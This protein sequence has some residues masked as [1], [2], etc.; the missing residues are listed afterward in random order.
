[1][2]GDFYDA[3]ALRDGRVGL[4]IGDVSGHGR[5]SIAQTALVRFTVRAYLVAG[6]EPRDAL[7]LSQSALEDKLGDDFV[8]VMLAVLTRTRRRSPTPAP[9]RAAAPEGRPADPGRDRGLR[10]ADRGGLGTGLRQTTVCLQADT[11]ICLYTDGLTEAMLQDRMPAGTSSR[12]CST[13]SAARPRRRSCSIGWSR[14]PTGRVTTWPFAWAASKPGPR[15]P[16]SWRSSRRAAAT[17]PGVVQRFLAACE[18]RPAD[19]NEA[20]AKAR[21]LSEEY[22][23]ALLRVYRHEHPPRVEVAAAGVERL[24]ADRR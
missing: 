21:T 11:T 7:K 15:P 4:I 14:R 17:S 13:A 9:P 1:M 5:T 8:T 12:G 6:L 3:V 18:I 24:A 23:A 2:A 22:G 20:V 16:I 10:T 19:L